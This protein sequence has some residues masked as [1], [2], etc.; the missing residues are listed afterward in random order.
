MEAEGVF[1]DNDRCD[2]CGTC[3]AVCSTDAIALKENS[4]WIDDVKCIL[5]LVCVEIC[6]LGALGVLS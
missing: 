6:P 1:V 4:V 2:F 5:C 3:V